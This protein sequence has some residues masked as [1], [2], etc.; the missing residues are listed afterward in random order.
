MQFIEGNVKRW[1][2]G[3]A[4]TEEPTPTNTIKNLEKIWAEEKAQQ[5]GSAK[6]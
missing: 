5:I 2:R 1:R 3:G 6:K 4:G